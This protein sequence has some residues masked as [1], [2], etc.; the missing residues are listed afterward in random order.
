MSDCSFARHAY[1]LFIVVSSALTLGF[2]DVTLS[3]HNIYVEVI[4]KV[5]SDI[6][7]LSFWIYE[8]SCI[9]R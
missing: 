3:G 5:V 7:V 2:T 6:S 4:R 8:I 9:S 1:L